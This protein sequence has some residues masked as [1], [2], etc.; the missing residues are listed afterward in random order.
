M[1]IPYDLFLEVIPGKQY[2]RLTWQECPVGW[3]LMHANTQLHT[4]LHISRLFSL[5]GLMLG[6]P[7]RQVWTLARSV[8]IKGL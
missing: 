4:V 3:L 8:M 1:D 2:T 5:L 7:G 6:Y